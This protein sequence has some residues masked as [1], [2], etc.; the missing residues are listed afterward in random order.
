[1]AGAGFNDHLRKQALGRRFG[2]VMI[3]EPFLTNKSEGQYMPSSNL[4]AL[5]SVCLL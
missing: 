3:P 4:L 5:L 2:N 1:M